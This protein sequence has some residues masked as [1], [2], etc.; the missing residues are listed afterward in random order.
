MTDFSLPRLRSVMNVKEFVQRV[1]GDGVLNVVKIERPCTESVVYECIS[2][3]EGGEILST[4][5]VEF[6]QDLDPSRF[7]QHLKFI[8]DLNKEGSFQV[9]PTLVATVDS[10]SCRLRFQSPFEQ[11]DLRGK[12]FVQDKTDTVLC[13][14]DNLQLW[15][16]MRSEGDSNV[17]LYRVLAILSL[18]LCSL[19]R[20]SFMVD[21]L[22]L[23]KMSVTTMRSMNLQWRN[24]VFYVDGLIGLPIFQYN[25][26]IRH[27]RPASAKDFP[28]VRDQIVDVW[29][30]WNVEGINVDAL[31]ACKTI[32]SLIDIV[33]SM[34][35]A[36]G[37]SFPQMSSRPTIMV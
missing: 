5:P 16:S 27:L 13:L 11:V 4:P 26:A 10:E 3:E 20:R 31:S 37:G 32:D 28:M 24:S 25:Y 7:G 1:C 8:S 17:K 34:V 6:V 35:W 18:Q 14:L 36:F 15:R 9:V 12:W 22:D 29:T 21:L 2:M 30:E 19:F 33:W 23:S